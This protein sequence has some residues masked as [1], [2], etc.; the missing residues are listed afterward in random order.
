MLPP[1]YNFTIL[2]RTCTSICIVERPIAHEVEA[3]CPTEEC[4]RLK[5]N[6]ALIW[7]HS[8]LITRLRCF[9]FCFFFLLCAGPVPELLTQHLLQAL[10][11]KVNCASYAFFLCEEATFWSYLNETSHSLFYDIT[12][13]YS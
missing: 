9:L 10:C 11:V 13:A 2:K 4:V 6:K 3:L 5:R 12:S 1:V 8:S 7:R